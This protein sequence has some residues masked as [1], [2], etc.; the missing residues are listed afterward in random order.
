MRMLDLCSGL[1]GASEAMLANGWEVTRIE[2][3][4]ELGYVPNTIICDVKDVEWW[5]MEKPDLI[6]ASPPCNEWSDGFHSKKATLRRDGEEYIPNL[7]ILNTCFEIIN[8]IKPK[9]WVIENVRGA[10]EFFNPILGEPTQVIDG[11]YLWGKF[12]HIAMPAAYKHRKISKKFDMHDKLRANK[13]AKIPFEVSL[14]LMQA[15]QEQTTLEDWFCLSKGLGSPVGSRYIFKI[16][17]DCEMCGVEINTH[18]P[19]YCDYCWGE[20][21]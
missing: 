8:D 3:N 10:R 15:I 14:Q 7:D 19:P 9:Y 12:P 18:R 11:I 2:N 5:A 21:E 16:L 4:K 17:M 20:E 13:R 6:W 1:G